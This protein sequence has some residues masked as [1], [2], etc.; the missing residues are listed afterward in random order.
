MSASA[1]VSPVEG[2][3]HVSD[4]VERYIP[5]HEFRTCRFWDLLTMRNQTIQQAWQE[6]DMDLNALDEK[7]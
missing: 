4:N 7:A 3:I 6:G 1:R 5:T 2:S